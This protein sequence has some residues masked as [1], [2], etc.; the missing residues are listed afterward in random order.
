MKQSFLYKCLGIVCLLLAIIIS[1]L[2][3]ERFDLVA[4]L[5]A[6]CAICLNF[7]LTFELIEKGVLKYENC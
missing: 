5:V 6:V 3:I 1:I 7:G 4:L 2:D